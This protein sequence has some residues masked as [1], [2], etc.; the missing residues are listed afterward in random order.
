MNEFSDYKE[1]ILTVFNGYNPPSDIVPAN[2]FEKT[3][4]SE[5]MNPG[6]G[7]KYLLTARV[8]FQ[9]LG[10]QSLGSPYRERTEARPT[11]NLY[12]LEGGDDKTHLKL[13]ENFLIMRGRK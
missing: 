13:F 4:A 6:K 10:R 7:V 1:A 12:K 9:S 2:E 3:V 5:N 8:I 11:F